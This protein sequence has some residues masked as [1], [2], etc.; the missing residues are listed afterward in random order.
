MRKLFIALGLSITTFTSFAERNPQYEVMQDDK[1]IAN[2][3]VR[4]L[5]SDELLITR[6]SVNDDTNDSAK[7][8]TADAHSSMLTATFKGQQ[9]TQFSFS[10][11]KGDKKTVEKFSQQGNIIRWTSPKD[12]EIGRAHV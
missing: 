1:V 10:S 9:L 11:T 6:Q 7:N 5:Q 4:Q 12:E 3:Q 2:I 8:S